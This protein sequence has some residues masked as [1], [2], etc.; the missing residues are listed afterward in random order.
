MTWMISQTPDLCFAMYV[1]KSALAGSES[2]QASSGEFN[3]SVLKIKRRSQ[4]RCSGESALSKWSLARY[5]CFLLS[6]TR[7]W[8]GVLH[9]RGGATGIASQ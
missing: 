8:I 6:S 5:G 3:A 1:V 9:A 7:A 4:N 2:E